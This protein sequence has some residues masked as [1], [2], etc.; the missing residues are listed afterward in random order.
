[1]KEVSF[2][3]KLPKIVFILEDPLHTIS[4]R[5]IRKREK[6]YFGERM[7]QEKSKIVKM[8]S[9]EMLLIFKLTNQI[10][11]LGKLS[12]V[13]VTAVTSSV[14]SRVIACRW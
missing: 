14:L 5:G 1:M 9:I 12:L 6:R 7:S 8:Q 13:V 2:E 11:L 4:K 10:K 3:S